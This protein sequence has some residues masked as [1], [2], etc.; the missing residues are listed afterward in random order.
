MENLTKRRKNKTDSEGMRFG[1][2]NSNQL[3]DS[4]TI[5]S[6]ILN[7]GCFFLVLV[8]GGLKNLNKELKKYKKNVLYI[9]QYKKK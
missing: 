2:P 8:L 4:L 9:I 5:Q 7:V 3:S 1:K 6:M